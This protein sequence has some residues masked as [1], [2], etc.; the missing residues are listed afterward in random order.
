MKS[1]KLI[2]VVLAALALTVVGAGTAMAHTTVKSTSPKNGS[3]VA[4]SLKSVKVLFSG[5]IRSGTLKVV[6]VSTGKK[7]SV[8]KG[9][10]DPRNVKRLTVRLKSGLA[11]GK[12]KANWSMVAADGHTQSGSFWF[13]LR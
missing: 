4:K 5:Q 3:T 1:R 9:G 7:V 2:L 10:R 11:K 8:G 6:R 13:K 12:Y